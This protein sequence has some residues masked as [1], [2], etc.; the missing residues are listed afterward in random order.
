[1]PT[2][3]RATA[4]RRRNLDALLRRSP[5]QPVFRARAARRLAVLGY[6]GID[7][8]VAFRAQMERLART[9]RPVGLEEVARAA[10]HRRPLPARSVLVTFDDGDRTVLTEALPVL[11]RLGI[12]AAVYVITDLID[13][14]HPYWW[15]EAAHLVAHGARAE[16]LRGLGPTAAVRRL[17]SLP[18]P[19]RRRALAELRATAAR[20]APRQRQLSSAELRTLADAGLAIGSHT[21]SHPCLDRCTDADL[22]TQL[23]RAHDRLTALTGRPPTS[24]AYPNGNYDPRADRVLRTLGYRTGFLFDHR[25]ADLAP[26]HR[27]RISRLR[28]NSHTGRDRFD[29]ILSGLHPAVHRLRGGS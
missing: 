13:S 17:K 14:D 15:T 19:E 9:A 22:D 20:Q 21:A 26:A 24:F 23:V 4:R 3:D 29:T 8:P 27:L 18:D 1:M 10:E 25:H 6:H 28:V 12:P 2:T 11:A 5:F 16:P 7:D